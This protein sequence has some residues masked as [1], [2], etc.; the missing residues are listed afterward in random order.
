VPSLD[1]NNSTPFEKCLNKSQE[2]LF[3]RSGPQQPAQQPA[4]AHTPSLSPQAGTLPCSRA[5][6]ASLHHMPP[7]LATGVPKQGGTPLAWM[8]RPRPPSS[9]LLF[10]DSLL[11]CLAV[12]FLCCLPH[13]R[14]SAMLHESPPRQAKQEHAH[15][16]VPSD[17]LA[18]AENCRAGW[19][20]MFPHLWWTEPTAPRWQICCLWWAAQS[21][22]PPR[23]APRHCTPHS[24]LLPPPS[25]AG[26]AAPRTAI[27]CASLATVDSRLGAFF[28]P[29]PSTLSCSEV[30][31][32]S[33]ARQ[34]STLLHRSSSSSATTESMS[35]PWWQSARV[36]RRPYRLARRNARSSLELSVPTM[37]LK[38][39]RWALAGRAATCVGTG[40]WPRA[41]RVLYYT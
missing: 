3:I 12:L 26:V 30:Q 41:V 6:R 10:P 17:Q 16:S 31:W 21:I 11:P 35:P 39:H 40:W 20:S 22:P 37:P 9:I 2:E 8:P 33:L 7:P 34:T 13:R 23:R 25:V 38:D 18:L 29:D 19:I 5:T 27:L 36:S 1:R 32:T 15:T 14:S 24:H 28:I 4:M